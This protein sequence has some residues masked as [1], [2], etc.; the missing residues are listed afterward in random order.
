MD[1]G[2]KPRNEPPEI[3]V[4][5]ELY[6]WELR[7]SQRKTYPE[8]AKQFE[9]KYRESISEAQISRILK[10]HRELYN[11]KTQEL[12]AAERAEQ[13]A[14]LDWAISQ[15]V[16]GWT[17]SRKERVK[18][19][20]SKETGV[21]PRSGNDY[22]KDIEAEEVEGQAGDPRF[23]KTILDASQRKAKLWG[24]DAAPKSAVGQD[25]DNPDPTG[26]KPWEALAQVIR[27]SRELSAQRAQALEGAEEDG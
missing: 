5:Q 17:D 23:L 26:A 22:N 19:T 2:R 3:R 25:E 10:K 14:L 21:D 16:L 20:T 9:E 13:A 1:R 12:A 15:A 8:I 24:L 7:V 4:E 18:K 27:E 11:D 6:V